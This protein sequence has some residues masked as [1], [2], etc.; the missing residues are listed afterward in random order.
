MLARGVCFLLVCCLCWDGALC[1]PGGM[2]GGWSPADLKSPSVQQMAAFSVGTYNKESSG[3][4]L[5]RMVQLL[6]AE[7]QV[8]AG[9]NYKL[10]MILGSTE[11][12]KSDNKPIEKCPLQSNMQLKKIQCR[13]QIY[14]VPWV[15]STTMSKKE[16]VSV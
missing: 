3:N 11:C 14:H 2:V 8:V 7:Q 4:T 12:R 1:L 9:M 15:P 5:Y 16:C 13:F 6:G 10:N